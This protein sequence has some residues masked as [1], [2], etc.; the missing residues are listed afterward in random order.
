MALFAVEPVCLDWD[1]GSQGDSHSWTPNLDWSHPHWL[2]FFWQQGIQYR[3]D[4]RRLSP[5]LLFQGKQDPTRHSFVNF[6][7]FLS[8][9]LTISYNIFLWVIQKQILLKHTDYK[10][11]YSV[12]R[13]R[14]HLSHMTWM[15]QKREQLFILKPF[16]H[17]FTPCKS[18]L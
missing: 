6:W 18:I 12:E 2:K 10:Y 14:K 9:T 1:L 11:I 4:L 8:N 15:Q 5:R 3:G 16:L 17:P 13:K 7:E